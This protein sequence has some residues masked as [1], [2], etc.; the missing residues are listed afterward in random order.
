MRIGGP[1][2]AAQLVTI[3]TDQGFAFEKLTDVNASDGS[4]GGSATDGHNHSEAGNLIY[5]ALFTQ[6]FGT[7]GG[8]F[9]NENTTVLADQAPLCISTDSSTAT[10]SLNVLAA[11]FF[12]PRGFATTDLVMIVDTAGG[13]APKMIADLYDSTMTLVASYNGMPLRP[14]DTLPL[15][16]GMM[17]EGGGGPSIWGI[18]FQVPSAGLYVLKLSTT[19]DQT[20][21]KRFI[22]SMHIFGVIDPNIRGPLQ[23]VTPVSVAVTG[24]N[25]GDPDNGAA[26]VG[27]DTNLINTDGPLN[28][29]ALTIMAQN[30]ALLAEL[31]TD[32][33]APGKT[34][35]TVTKGHD[36]SAATFMGADEIE[37]CHWAKAFGSW[38]NALPTGNNARAPTSP[39]VT[40]YDKAVE[41]R[42]WLPVSANVTGGGAG[43]STLKISVLAYAETKGGGTVRCDFASVT[44]ERTIANNSNLQL[45]TFTNPWAFDDAAV[46]LFFFELKST[47]VTTGQATL[48]AACIY[49]DVP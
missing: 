3:A 22:R 5:R 33:P 26:W 31:A 32:Q 23:T 4:A 13:G 48:V 2:K 46:N 37:H 42:I 44:Q 16:G 45:L 27:V 21:D 24:V 9:N 14:A 15:A 47:T 12:V 6:H 39:G 41:G 7:D 19:V 30:N 38:D 25:V 49:N 20:V 8:L 11:L 34:A 10:G 18:E 17:T 43:N 1:I 29:G 36:H 40:T 35:K 28:A